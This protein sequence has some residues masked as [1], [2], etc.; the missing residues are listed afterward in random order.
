MLTGISGV[1]VV[2]LT[3]AVVLVL[4]QSGAFALSRRLGRVNVVDVTWGLGFGLVALVAVA[5]SCARGPASGS[6]ALV[7]A[8]LVVGWGVRLAVHIGRQSAGKGEDPRYVEMLDKHDG[9]DADGTPEPGPAFLRVFLLQAAAQ[10]VVSLPLQAL[11]LA[12]APAGAGLPVAVAGVVLGLFGVVYEAVADAQLGAYKRDPDRPPIM[13]R[14]LWRFSR[15]PNYFGDAC[16]WWG[17]WVAV[18][19]T[20]WGAFTVVSPLLMTYFLV[21]ATGARPMDQHM[22]GRPGWDDYADRISFFVPLPPKRTGRFGAGAERG[23]E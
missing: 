10:W 2:T 19:A 4:L 20:G 14:G 12:P 18:A 8:A 1:L 22:S 11:A 7:V 5:F 17:L 6:H 23:A 3:S 13:S 9:L 21:W 16:V 15:H